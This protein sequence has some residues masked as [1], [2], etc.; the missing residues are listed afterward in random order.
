MTEEKA[1]NFLRKN[2]KIKS[3]D[4]SLIYMIQCIFKITFVVIFLCSGIELMMLL[5]FYSKTEIISMK[6]LYLWIIFASM[7]VLLF[8]L[9]KK[10]NKTYF[11]S[12]YTF[13]CLMVMRLYFSK[14]DWK[15]IKKLSKNIKISESNRKYD[16]Y[17]LLKLEIVKKMQEN[18][19]IVVFE[20]NNIESMTAYR[21]MDSWNKEVR[22]INGDCKFFLVHENKKALLINR[23]PDF[24]DYQKDVWAELV[25]ELN[26]K[27]HGNFAANFY[28]NTVWRGFPKEITMKSNIK[29]L[30]INKDQEIQRNVKRKI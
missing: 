29:K 1:F 15:E 21:I 30:G 11:S 24:K 23:H 25:K 17:G 6:Y 27:K 13:T 3:F 18:F 5:F 4:S 22:A 12:L 26:V 2:I 10:K 20:I 8:V 14:D 16:Y 28:S 7:F 9:M 19:D